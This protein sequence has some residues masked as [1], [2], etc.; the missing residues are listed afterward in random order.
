MFDIS[1]P[2]YYGIISSKS[3]VIVSIA[4]VFS[5]VSAFSV[6]ANVLVI[7]AIAVSR[8]RRCRESQNSGNTHM[9]MASLAV[10]DAFLGAFI[11]PMGIYNVLNNR[12]WGLGID[13]CMAR[14]ICH[15]FLSRVSV[16]HILCLAVDR[17]IAVCKPLKYR[18]LSSK[19]NL[20]MICL[21]WTIPPVYIGFTYVGNW[22]EEIRDDVNLCPLLEGT[23]VFHHQSTFVFTAVWLLGVLPL[24]VTYLLYY[25]ILRSVRSYQKR[26]P[27]SYVYQSP[28]S[29]Q[30]DQGTLPGPS[31][32]SNTWASV[33]HSKSHEY[34]D[35]KLEEPTK[36]KS[37]SV[38][39]DQ[40]SPMGS[41]LSENNVQGEH[42]SEH[43]VTELGILKTDSS[44]PQETVGTR[45]GTLVVLPAPI[46]ASTKD[47]SVRSTQE[48]SG[49]IPNKN[50]ERSSKPRSNLRA[51]KT[52]GVIVICFS[53]C[54]L[55]LSVN[56]TVAFF[57]KTGNP[58]L[59][60][61]GIWSSY[62]N[63]AVNPVLYLFQKSIRA[64]IRSLICSC[65]K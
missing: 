51:V 42:G 17:Y 47:F 32:G 1:S 24:S 58:G 37:S 18:I 9:L 34:T 61:F 26:K 60:T 46:T 43:K 15:T 2:S 14:E 19:T 5:I 45:P 4:V 3:S 64:A 11:M 59:S 49:N 44:Q 13:L 63:S 22:H 16:L 27:V 8:G 12:R 57:T 28:T 41:M 50:Q 39:L 20:A 30:P 7:V 36:M 65:P 23:C 53:V 33:N 21:C 54:W 55:P 48:T 6:V 25:C 62:V 35:C 52:I 40:T 38:S 29:G 31:K 56:T 10:S